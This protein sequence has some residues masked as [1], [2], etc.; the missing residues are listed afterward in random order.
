MAVKHLTQHSGAQ[1]ESSLSSFERELEVVRGL[2]HPHVVSYLAVRRGV[3]GSLDILY[4]LMD[5]GSLRGLLDDFGGLPESV[6]QNYTRQIILGL[7]FLHACG[8]SHRDLKAANI[9]VRQGSGGGVELK[10]ADFGSAHSAFQ[11]LGKEGSML[12]QGMPK[13]SS[14]YLNFAVGSPLWTAPEVLRGQVKTGEGW[15]RA[16]VWSLGCVGIEMA[17][18]RVP[19][20]GAFADP[21]SA[22]AFIA[23]A[24]SP[25]P[26]IPE[27]LSSTGSSF[28]KCCFH[29]SAEKRLLLVHLLH[30]P[31]LAGG[32][33]SEA[34]RASRSHTSRRKVRP[35]PVVAQSSSAGVG[36]ASMWRRSRSTSPA[37]APSRRLLFRS[38]SSSPR[39]STARSIPRASAPTPSSES[40]P[41][42]PSSSPWRTLLAPSRSRSGSLTPTRASTTDAFAPRTPSPSWKSFLRARSPSPKHSS[43]AVWRSK[44]RS[45]TT[46][47]DFR[48]RSPRCRDT[49]RIYTGQAP[50]S[51]P[52]STSCSAASRVM[53]AVVDGQ[54]DQAEKGNEERMEMEEDEGQPSAFTRTIAHEWL[55]AA[56]CNLELRHDTEREVQWSDDLALI[57]SESDAESSSSDG[58]FSCA[59]DAT[60]SPACRSGSSHLVVRAIANYDA[61]DPSELTLKEGELVEVLRQ[62]ENGWWLGA[63]ECRRGWFPSTF[64]EFLPDD[65]GG[66]DQEDG[67]FEDTDGSEGIHV[68]DGP[69]AIQELIAPRH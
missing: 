44:S 63:D 59:S 10:L 7:A 27:G 60:D 65:C 33:Q 47:D 4:E 15:R 39:S 9:L 2:R 61:E 37:P 28:I 52:C 18:G 69:A 16:D 49:P 57:I 42:S 46:N 67:F 1:A 48:I 45:G 58:T 62:T 22:L 31:F 5:L 17:T 50:S 38:K 3:P 6:L 25:P 35:R 36:W 66:S 51:A 20:E 56:R 30:H 11:Q 41:A 32:G 40:T 54:Q 64:C 68:A 13:V 26:P 23:D 43:A 19:W 29:K 12:S 8:I 14:R 53:D 21:Y 55:E 24:D 34:G